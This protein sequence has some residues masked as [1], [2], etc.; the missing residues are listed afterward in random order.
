M[1]DQAKNQ[2]SV[3]SLDRGNANCRIESR[4]PGNE[5]AWLTL[6]HES[7]MNSI[8]SAMIADLLGI[9][10]ELKNRDALRAVV[11]SGDG[12]RAFVGGAFLPE[13]EGLDPD[14]GRA[15]ITRLHTA[16]QAVR[17]CPVPVIARLQ[18][19]CLGAGTEL[20]AACDFRLADH[21]LVIGM[22]EVRV[23][24]PSV[25]EAALLPMLIGWGK[26]RE[27]LLTAA[28]YN[29]E[30]AASM[31]FVD[32]L[33]EVGNL[34]ERVEE[35]VSQIVSAGPLAVRAQKQLINAWEKL[36]PDEGIKL[37]IDY[38]AR[39]YETDEPRRMMAPLLKK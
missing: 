10:A 8:G 32:T 19:Y 34:D 28:N 2:T 33:A 1:S 3:H 31:G 6:S 13:L 21:S 38:L 22:P 4:S 24:L 26:T 17:D 27:M 11:I 39:A 29:A 7:K 15:F 12:D 36:S 5:V 25:I 14:A 16:C 37:G 9:F 30:E 18:G 35:R 20:A 23:G